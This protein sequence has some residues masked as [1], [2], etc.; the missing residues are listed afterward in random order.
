ML[1]IKLIDPYCLQSVSI[2]LVTYFY[3]VQMRYWVLLLSLS[4]LQLVVVFTTVLYVAAYQVLSLMGKAKYTDTGSL[5]DAGMDLNAES[6]T[7]E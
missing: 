5:I 7:A 6:G 1:K 4:T 3:E 2:H